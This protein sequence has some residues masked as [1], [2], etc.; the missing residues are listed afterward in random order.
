MTQITFS[1][2]FVAGKFQQRDFGPVE[3][4]KRYNQSEPPSYDLRKISA[5]VSLYYSDNDM[6]ATVKVIYLNTLIPLRSNVSRKVD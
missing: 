1:G 6:M 3:N 2:I 5:P 4:M